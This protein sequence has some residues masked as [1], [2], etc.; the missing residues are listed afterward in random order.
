M[1]REHRRWVWVLLALV[2]V[3]PGAFFGFRTLTASRP[4]PTPA[5][6]AAPVTP[7]TTPVPEEFIDGILAPA[8]YWQACTSESICD[9]SELTLPDF[10]RPLPPALRR[11]LRLPVLQRGQAC[12][13]SPAHDIATTA[14]FGGTALGSGPVGPIVLGHGPV[15]LEPSADA[16]KATSIFLWFSDPSYQGPWILRGA[17][18]DGTSLVTFGDP[19]ALTASFVVPPISLINGAGGYQWWPGTTRVRAPGCYAVQVDGLSFSYD[20]VFQVVAAPK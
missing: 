17:Q 5:Q 8:T 19:P 10:Q 6:T 14:P 1:T 20:I 18:L 3:V 2:A 12:P 16:N 13:T 15:E 9:A 7:A 4:V 11:P